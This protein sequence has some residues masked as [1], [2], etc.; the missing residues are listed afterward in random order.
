MT[1]VA[2]DGPSLGE[3]CPGFQSYS[4]RVLLRVAAGLAVS[5]LVAA[6]IAYLP[7]LQR[8]LLSITPGWTLPTG[9]GLVLLAATVIVLLAA[10][11]AGDMLSVRNGNRLYWLLSILVGGAVGMVGF[12]LVYD[13]LF[14]A[15]LATACALAGLGVLGR[16]F[17][18]RLGGMEHFVMVGLAGSAAGALLSLGLGKGL[19]E[20]LVNLA[21]VTVFTGLIAFGARRLPACYR[22]QASVNDGAL[23]LF[24]SAIKLFQAKSCEGGRTM[25]SIAGGS[26]PTP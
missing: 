19:L 12:A 22:R 15:F 17:H 23:A 10:S 6:A 24:L 8:S 4:I 5:G 9:F 25:P 7:P 3:T 1:Q 13:T 21:G 26:A 18:R 2:G 14:P 20:L 11:A 16:Q